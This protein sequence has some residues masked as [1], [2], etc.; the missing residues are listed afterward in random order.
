[1]SVQINQQFIQDATNV[2]TQ[3]VAGNVNLAPQAKDL[4]ALI[5][6]FGGND[7]AELKSAGY[8]SEDPDAPRAKRKAAKGRLKQFLGQ[9][10]DVAK[11]AGA[12]LLAKRLES[13]GL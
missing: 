5:D 3:N 2:I 10:G 11:E 1:M 13:K 8:E 9:L 4:M 6:R 12:E 7:A